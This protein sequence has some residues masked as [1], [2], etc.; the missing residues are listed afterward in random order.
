[1]E[2]CNVT[3]IIYLKIECAAKCRAFSKA[4]LFNSSWINFQGRL[5]VR[6]VT[7][8][9]GSGIKGGGIRDQKS[10]IWD[11]SPGIRHDQMPWDREQHFF[12]VRDQ[13]SSCTICGPGTEIC[14][15]F[16]IKDQKFG[17]KNGISD[18]ETHIDTTLICNT[19][20]LILTVFI[21][22]ICSTLTYIKRHMQVTKEIRT[23]K[24]V[25]SVRFFRA[26]SSSP[27]CCYY[28][29]NRI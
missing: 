12:F 3:V 27:K 10:G 18:E 28:G 14:H 5:H 11:H 4:F 24:I 21:R 2:I 9:V 23:V 17:Y 25:Y 26:L 15:Y 1:M 6:V 19:L 7:R 20:S 8:Y 22:L 16:R 13:G 29:T